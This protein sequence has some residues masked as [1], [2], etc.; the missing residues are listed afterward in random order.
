MEKKRIDFT[1]KADGEFYKE[2]IKFSLAPNQFTKL[3]QGFVSALAAEA[4]D[5]EIS[6]EGR[7]WDPVVRY[8]ERKEVK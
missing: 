6:F 2:D 3:I 4:K 8:L 1:L 5:V 7:N